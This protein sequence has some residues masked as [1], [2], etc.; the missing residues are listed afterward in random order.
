LVLAFWS[1]AFFVSAQQNPSLPAHAAFAR[2]VLQNVART[3]LLPPQAHANGLTLAQS[4]YTEMRSLLEKNPAEFVR[5]AF[6]STQRAQLPPDIRSLIEERIKGR[7]SFSIACALPKTNELATFPHGYI[8]EVRLNGTVYRASVFGNWRNQQTVQDAQIDGVALGDAIALGDSLTPAEQ[9]AA[10]A[11]VT[12]YAPSTTG[13]NTLLYMITQFADQSTDPI[14]EAT[15]LSQMAVVSNFWLNASYNSVYLKGLIHSTQACDFVHIRIPYGATNYVNNFSGILS[16]A[17]SAASAQGFTAGNYNLYAVV[18]TDSGFSY[19]GESWIGAAG[20]HWVTPYTTLR[21]AGHELGHNLGLYHA[22]YWRTDSP[23]PFG[24]DSNP[25]GYVVDS[26]E[27]E[28][29]EY[30]HYFSVMSAQ[31]GGEWDDATK[32]IYNP[33][34]KVRLGWLSGSQVLYAASSG[35]YRLF[36][37]DARTTVGTPRAIRIETPATDYTGYGHLYWLQYRYAPW[38]TAMNWFQ[39]GVEVDVAETGYGSDG[40]ILLD[41]TPYSDDQS[42]PF[43]NSSSPPGGWWTIDNSDKID[44]ALLVGRSYDDTPAG[45]HITPLDTGS[46]GT[47]E[48]YIDV[49]INLGTFP[50]NHPPVIT[51]FT[52]ST[53]QVGVGQSVNFNV[54]ATDPDG[55]SLAYSWD[56]GDLQVWTPSGLNSPTATKSWSSAGQY[57]VQARVSDMKGGVTTASQVITVGVTSSTNQVWGR[58]LWGGLPVYGARIWPNT[59]NGGATAQVWTDSDGSYVLEGLAPGSYTINCQAANLTFTAQF[60]NPIVITSGNFYGADFFANQPL[61]GPAGSGFVIS[62][63]VTDPINGAAGIE[64]RG[65]GVVAITDSLGNYQLTNFPNGSYTVAPSDPSWAFSPSS[66]GVTISSANSTGNNFSRVAPYSITGTISGLPTTGSSPA[67]IVYLSNGRS[68]LA[69]KAGKGSWTYTLNNVPSG[70]YSVTAFLSGYSIVPSGFSNPLTISANAS[71]INFNA[72]S[73]SGIAGA[74]SG[75][76]LRY[77]MPLRG[78][79][80]SALQAGS[81]I[82]SVSS[83]SDGY[84]R[85]DNLPAGA[86]T[87]NPALSGFSFSPSPLSVGSVPSSGN[88]FN[89]TSSIAPPSISSFTANPSIVPTPAGSTALSATASGSGALTY[90]WDALIAPV[91]VIFSTN[92][93]ASS[94]TIASFLA[95]G[96]YTLRARVTDSSGFSVTSNLNVTVTAGPGSLAVTPFKV[97]LAGGQKVAFHAN[98]WDQLGNP[99]TASPAWSASGG[100]TIDANGVFTATT[101]GGPD[102]ITANYASL[103]ASGSVWVTSSSAAPFSIKGVPLSKSA[104]MLTWTALSGSTYRIQYKNQLNASTWT[105][106]TPDILAT[107]SIMSWSET[108]STTSRF[109]RILLMQ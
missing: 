21:T 20:S 78:V 39:N 67:P 82:G 59:W 34:E 109:Y 73:T 89:A 63:Q 108:P 107:N 69:T 90:S 40:S 24:Q 83:D 81:T 9:A 27:G 54:S 92:D 106:V 57:R 45:I 100:G 28:W 10:G 11:T 26:V 55:D 4:R 104:F 97:R 38:N 70:L 91:P 49:T 64:V 47:G 74:V 75:R 95:P 84:Y 93:S 99:I 19:A 14:D 76:I 23:Q 86:Y 31:Y 85:I 18:T 44:G 98:A 37:H 41:M 66:R 65:G 68:A 12:A 72:T 32:P 35:T 7:G 15:A 8:R 103:S 16:D 6:P 62:G 50:T 94:S 105:S 96:L 13:P 71:G 5:Q 25:G 77:G 80:V 46:N 29:V 51:A 3:N 60:T 22:N 33:A 87:V 88:N 79:N 43:Y 30:G 36:R 53:N 52:V 48:E 102:S 101:A 58:V 2:W 61:P 42:S 17:Q 1:S 56:F